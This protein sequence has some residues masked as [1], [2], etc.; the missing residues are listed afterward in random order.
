MLRRRRP[1]LRGAMIG[2]AAATAGKRAAPSQQ[3][4]QTPAP[5]PAPA[6]TDDLTSKL[7]ELAKLK[8]TGVLTEDEFAAA[9]QKLLS[10]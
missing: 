5:G 10:G 9:K 4:E 8:E 1:L 3:P 7:M 6:P 2:G